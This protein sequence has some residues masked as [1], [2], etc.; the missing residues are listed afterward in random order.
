M[1]NTQTV[2]P[3]ACGEHEIFRLLQQLNAGSSP[4]LWGTPKILPDV[5]KKE[6]FIP[7]PVG[8][9]KTEV[10]RVE[11]D[12]VHPHACGEHSLPTVSFFLRGGSSPRL[13]GTLY[14]RIFR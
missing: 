14:P 13:W 4:R 8:N 2:H 1:I 7:T 12:T 3:H 11:P 6:R 10:N 9:T 5:V